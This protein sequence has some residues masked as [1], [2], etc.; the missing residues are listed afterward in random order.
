M[1]HEID[2]VYDTLWLMWIALFFAWIEGTRFGGLVNWHRGWH[3]LRRW[4]RGER[5]RRP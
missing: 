1:S 5:R 2:R 4:W 3:E